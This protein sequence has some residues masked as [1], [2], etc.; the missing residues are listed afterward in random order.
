MVLLFLA[1]GLKLI[2][3]DWVKRTGHF[4][5]NIM[6]VMF[7][8]PAVGLLSCLDAVKENLIPVC[9]M[10][11]VSLVLVF[12]VSGFVTKKAM[13]KGAKDHG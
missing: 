3:L 2:K 7:V 13:G 12:F 11:V 5:V 9:V 8:S 6:A 10:M 1:L 4:L